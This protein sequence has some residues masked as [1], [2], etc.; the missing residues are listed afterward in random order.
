MGKKVT[1]RQ[2]TLGQPITGTLEAYNLYEILVKT[3]KGYIVI[4]KHSIATIEEN[5]N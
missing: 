1:I 2:V 5:K 3:T 4:F